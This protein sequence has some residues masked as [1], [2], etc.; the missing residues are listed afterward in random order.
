[1]LRKI[2][3]LLS[4]FHLNSLVANTNMTLPVVELDPSLYPDFADE[5]DFENF[6]LAYERQMKAFKRRPLKGSLKLNGK[7]RKLSLIKESLVEFKKLVDITLICL[8][9]E[10]KD[11]CYSDFNNSVYERFQVFVPK[12]KEGKAFFTG[13]Y[14]PVLEASL[15]KNEEYKYAI[16][17]YPP[18]SIAKK[19]GRTQIHFDQALSGKNLELFFVKDLFDLYLLDVEGGG[20][21]SYHKNGRFLTQNLSYDGSNSKK[22]GWISSYMFDQGYIKDKSISSQRE[23]LQNNPDKW[24]EIYSACE[25]VVYF[26][27][28]E[29]EPAGLEDIPLTRDR[30]AAQDKKYF[31]RKGVLTFVKAQRPIIESG[32]VK[33]INFSRFFI[34][35]DTG[36]V[37]KG[38]ARADLYFGIGKEGEL[39]A[40]NLKSHGELFYLF[41]K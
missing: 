25:N 39:E 32:K 2:L 14:S 12:L 8:K 37:I 29:D 5:L 15:T 35:Q 26:R 23:F 3:I 17:K 41:L 4:V 7:V 11:K 9:K 38:E 31:K 1:M 6:D 20:R 27:K 10:S 30:S 28:S 34:D 19:Y 33:Q 22:F 21:V 18:N 24:R 40:N 36:G 13:Y 16:Y